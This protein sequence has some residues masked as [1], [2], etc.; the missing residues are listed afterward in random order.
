MRARLKTAGGGELTT[1]TADTRPT[2]AEVDA[3]IAQA[4][5]DVYTHTGDVPVVLKPAAAAVAALGTAMLIESGYYPEQIASGRSAWEAFR[6]MYNDRLAS[7]LEA[8]EDVKNTGS[9]QPDPGGVQG[10]SQYNKPDFSFDTELQVGR[11][12]W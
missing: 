8:A 2:D 7:L 1:F 6:Q 12:Y 11:V 9:V 5:E 3:L 10:D 4:A